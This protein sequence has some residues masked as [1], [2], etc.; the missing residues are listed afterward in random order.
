MPLLG[1][2]VNNDSVSPA[3][4][5]YLRHDV[6][7][8]RVSTDCATASHPTPTLIKKLKLTAS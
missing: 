2:T 3:S 5:L 4:M 1:T 6:I 7:T 8:D